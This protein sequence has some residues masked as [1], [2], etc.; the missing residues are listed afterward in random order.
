LNTSVLLEQEKR[1][2]GSDRTKPRA[3]AYGT[4]QS[5]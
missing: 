4:H 3:K 5:D 2:D 1:N